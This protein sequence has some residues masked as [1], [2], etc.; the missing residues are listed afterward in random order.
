MCKLR[1]R[2]RSSS[3]VVIVAVVIVG[4]VLVGAVRALACTIV[5]SPVPVGRDFRVEVQGWGLPVQGLRVEVTNLG[6]R[7]VAETGTDGSAGFYGFLPGR[8]ELTVHRDGAMRSHAVIQVQDQS[9]KPTPV[10]P[11]H[12][13]DKKPVRTRTLRGV[14]RGSRVKAFHVEL[15]DGAKVV[16][17]VQAS[18]RGEFHF[19]A[20]L[21][22]GLYSLR[23]ADGLIPVLVD[24]AAATERV[25]IAMVSTSCGLWWAD[26]SECAL[27]E[28]QTGRITGGEV[29][30]VS[31][32]SIPGATIAVLGREKL[33]ADDRG[34]FGAL[35]L[36]AGEYQLEVSGTGFFPLRRRLRVVSSPSAAAAALRIELGFRGCGA[37]AAVR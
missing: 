27:A 1:L 25:D 12:W 32:A 26:Q 6:G 35:E 31:G 34:R 10:V 37:V 4:A 14:L 13:P 3:S 33:Q 30:D 28:F 23:L 5:E 17:T 8:Y 20:Q 11:M 22:P 36:P 7:W 2:R 15:R 24:P 18:D 19:E 9:S 29:L 16:E 21:A